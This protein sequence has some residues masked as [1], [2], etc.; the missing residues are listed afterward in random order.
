MQKKFYPA[1]ASPKYNELRSCAWCGSMYGHCQPDISYNLVGTTFTQKKVAL[2][3][4]RY[5]LFIVVS[6]N[7]YRLRSGWYDRR[8]R[9]LIKATLLRNR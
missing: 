2:E 3:N 9:K 6:G 8:S 1:G 5:F 4:C 7:E